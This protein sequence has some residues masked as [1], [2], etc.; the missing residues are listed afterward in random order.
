MMCCVSVHASTQLIA[1]IIMTEQEWD[2]IVIGAG[3]HG[4]G[5]AQV[6]AAH[7]YRVLL[8]EQC[9]SAACAT[10]SKSSKLIHGGLRYLETGQFA[11]VQECL[12]ERKYLLRNAPHLVKIKPFYLPIYRST[13]RRP[14]KITAG[15]LLYSWFSGRSYHRVQKKDWTL[16]DGLNTEDLDA[17]FCYYDA[18]TDDARLTRAVLQS[19]A[20]MGAQIRYDAHVRDAEYKPTGVCV[21]MRCGDK[22]SSVEAAMVINASGPWV[23]ELHNRLVASYS[24]ATLSP[25]VSLVQGAHIILPDTIAHPYYLEA[26]QDKRAVF[27]LPWVL[28]GEQRVMVGTTETA[29]NGDPATVAP[30]EHEIDYLLEVYNHYFRRDLQRDKVL[31]SFAGLRVLPAGE[32]MAFAKS[33]DTLFV[34]DDE[35]RPRV[36]SILGGKLTAYRAN[37]EKLIASLMPVL[38]EKDPIADTTRLRLPIVD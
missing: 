5:V 11:L 4:A 14:W 3:I 12:R 36:V 25:P 26:P 18:Q 29:F 37:A 22:D 10:S 28:D 7:G 30:T 27:V 16:L 17:V 23:D 13:T 35:N 31:A 1:L 21:N 20:S 32:D 33:R 8:L 9:A 15:M 24:D 34:R 6:A 19:A 38:P 2:I